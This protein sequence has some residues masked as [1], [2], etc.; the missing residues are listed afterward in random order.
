M[1]DT[2]GQL[3]PALWGEGDVV[4]PQRTASFVVQN[5]IELVLRK[6]GKMKKWKNEKKGASSMH[7]MHHGL[8]PFPMAVKARP[9]AIA[10]EV[11]LV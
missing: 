3:S 8:L 1:Q 11:D 6:T 7:I 2:L 9:T 5:H 4:V 10:P